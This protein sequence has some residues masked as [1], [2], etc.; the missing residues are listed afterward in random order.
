MSQPMN[1]P[2]QF[3]W[4]PVLIFL[5]VGIVWFLTPYVIATV[6][7]ASGSPASISQ[8]GQFGD[9][10]GA[11]SALFSGLAFAGV[12]IN[13]WLQRETTSAHQ[14][15]ARDQMKLLGDVIRAQTEVASSAAQ[16]SQGQAFAIAAGIIQADKVRL[17]RKLTFKLL[18][19]K[20]FVLWSTTERA[21]AEVVCHTF[22]QIGIM[23]KNGMVKPQTIYDGWYPT[24]MESWKILEPFIRSKRKEYGSEN[25]GSGF[26]YLFD[27]M[28]RIKKAE[29]DRLASYQKYPAPNG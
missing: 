20:D 19:E 4:W 13:L 11:V 27:E 26:R 8:A 24:I 3:L 18:R 22:D 9:Q 23:I 17:A 12:V 1:R 16:A 7:I 2:L 28:R 5:G 15:L 10:F 25:A 21:Q 6:L 29:A 14:I